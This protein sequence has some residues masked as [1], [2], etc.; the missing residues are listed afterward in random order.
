MRYCAQLRSIR[1]NRSQG[2]RSQNSLET[3]NESVSFRGR[4]VR[5]VP[6]LDRLPSGNEAMRVQAPSKANFVS[7]SGYPLPI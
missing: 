1:R 6:R 7:N 3:V 4:M 2:V 5:S